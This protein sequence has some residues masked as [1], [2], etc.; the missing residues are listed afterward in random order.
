MEYYTARHRPS[1]LSLSD[2][3][4][5]GNY[6]LCVIKIIGIFFPLPVLVMYRVP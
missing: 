6:P 3:N 2:A 4:F 5:D 1:L